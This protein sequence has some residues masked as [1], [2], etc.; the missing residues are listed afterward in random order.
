MK[1]LET[2]NFKHLCMTIGN[3][4][5]SY[6]DSL[7]YYECLVW[8]CKYIKDTVIPAVNN[9]SEAITEL[10][11]LYVE[12]K[13]YVDDY[14]E[15][16]DVQEQINNKLDDMAMSG[17]LTEII[18]QY[19]QLAGVLA[20]DT[21]ADL[22]VAE[23]IIEGSIV[24]TLGYASIDDNKG[25]FYKVR[26]IINT[27]VVDEID[28][29]ALADEDLVA[30]RIKDHKYLEL[31]D[32]CVGDGVTDVSEILQ[33]VLDKCAEE[34]KFLLVNS[35]SYLINSNIT[36]PTGV[37]IIG[38]NKEN[39]TFIGGTNDMDMFNMIYESGA[40]ANN[41]IK[42]LQLV[43]GA[44]NVD[45]I[46]LTN[47]NRCCIENVQFIGLDYNIKID[48]GGLHRIDNCSSL[49]TATKKAGRLWFGS[50][51]QSSYGSVFTSVNSYHVDGGGS[52][53]Q[54]VQTP[55][56]HLNRAVGMHFNDIISNDSNGTG[57]FIVMENDSQGN[58][59]S[60]CTIVAYDR[61][62]Q[63]LK[64]GG[65]SPIANTFKNV[66]VDQC[67]SYAYIITGAKNLT[68]DG[69]HITSSAVSTDKVINYMEGSDVL[70]V[71]VTNLN[72]T[73][74]YSTNGTGLMLAGT[75]KVIVEDCVFDSCYQGISGENSLQDCRVMNNTFTDCNY[76]IVGN[77][78]GHNNYLS[79]NEGYYPVSMVGSPS[80][81]ASDTDYTNDTGYDAR[82]FISGGTINLIKING[83]GGLFNGGMVYL[84]KGETI[85]INYTGSPSWQ[86]LVM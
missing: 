21:V 12:L 65:Y 54:G 11:G 68:I 45:G 60:N 28:L 14:F 66:D 73:G 81:P 9:N 80:F 52:L 6:V 19:L 33:D 5:A 58:I 53:G 32:Y 23:N 51:D 55:A 63:I 61:A 85:Q 27:D 18:A 31:K 8:L 86:W 7:S 48:R 26:E 35:G 76:S 16:L 43:S 79:N 29:I 77:W 15:N 10:Q 78:Q 4:P 1:H 56:I 22:K 49:G 36:I 62:V 30:E 47:A 37:S 42:N 46:V 84:R 13:E 20:Y 72:V 41:T 69:G 70:N 74:Y 44:N 67:I 71:L 38:E 39:T 40:G 57:T 34:H 83:A 17:Q 50:T 25:S 64:S 3:L 82:I 75:H 2:L 24:K 59:F